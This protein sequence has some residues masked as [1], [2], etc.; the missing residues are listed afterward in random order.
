VK[1]AFYV[2]LL[3]PFAAIPVFLLAYYVGRWIAKFIPNGRIKAILT[4]PRSTRS[5]FFE[6]LDARLFWLFKSLLRKLRAK[7]TA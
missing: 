6:R 4:K 2:A 5:L 3:R 1:D 7:K